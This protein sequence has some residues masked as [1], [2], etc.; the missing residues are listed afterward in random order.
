MAGCF[1][2]VAF[3][4]RA[5]GIITARFPFQGVLVGE[6]AVSCV[7]GT[8]AGPPAY[9]TVKSA[10]F[11]IDT[12]NYAPRIATIGFRMGNVLQAVPSVNAVGGVAGVF[13]SDRRPP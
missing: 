12:D 10:A 9:P 6:A 11:Q 3:T 13:I 1:G 2:D 5:G 7:A 4:M 8:I